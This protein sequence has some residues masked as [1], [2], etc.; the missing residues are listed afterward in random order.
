[1]RWP[2][3]TPMD[4]LC[5]TLKLRRTPPLLAELSVIRGFVRRV[6]LRAPTVGRFR[7]GPNTRGIA[8][9]AMVAVWPWGLTVPI[10]PDRTVIC[11]EVGRFA[12]LQA[13]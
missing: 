2:E 5:Q 1:M 10:P 4:R 13:R 3:G 9:P 7:I 11:V 8:S 12:W 6:V